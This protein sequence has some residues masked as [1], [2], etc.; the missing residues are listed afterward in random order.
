VCK[1]GCLIDD[2]D[3]TASAWFILPPITPE[4][5]IFSVPLFFKDP[6]LAASLYFGSV[7]PSQYRVE[8]PGA[9]SGARQAILDSP[10]RVR[11]GFHPRF[12]TGAQVY[13]ECSSSFVSVRFL[14]GLLLVAL[15]AKWL[16]FSW[17]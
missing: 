1:H 8:G 10:R 13:E 5:V 16:C 7:V 15:L 6:R 4:C 3:V 17:F 14:I 2:N 12:K 11:A 9:W